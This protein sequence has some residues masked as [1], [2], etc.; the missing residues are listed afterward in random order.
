MVMRGIGLNIVSGT[1]PT[2]SLLPSKENLSRQFKVSNSTLREALQ[3]LAT[4]GMIHAKT[5]VG[6]RVL[7]ERNWNLFDADI[8]SWRFATGVDRRFLAHLFALRQAFE[9]MA[10]A[11]MAERHDL[12]AGRRLAQLATR[13]TDAGTDREAFASADLAF[14]LFILENAGNP[15]LQS[16]GALIRTALAASFTMSAPGTDANEAQRLSQQEHGALADAISA[17]DTQAAAGAMMQ[18]IRRG[19]S[20]ICGGQ[21]TELAAIQLIDFKP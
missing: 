16:I 19:W 17:G 13:L 5:R 15:F 12:E 9:P 10:A 11:M 4:K 2:G 20:A 6:T 8:L 3:K 18:V 1:Y 14:H 21:E 7:E